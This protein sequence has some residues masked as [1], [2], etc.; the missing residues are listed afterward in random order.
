MLSTNRKGAIAETAIVHQAVRLGIDV[1]KPV[2]EGGRYDLIF[3]SSNVLVRAQCKWAVRQ[4]DVIPVRCYS[5]RRS[6]A[7]FL[8][9]P[10]IADE[11][12]AIVAY[13]PELDRCYFLPL[14]LFG[15]RT[16]IQLRLAEAR[17]NQ[18]AGINWADD[19]TLERL[20]LILERLRGAIAQL[21][22][23]LPG[24]QEGTGSSPVGSTQRRSSKTRIEPP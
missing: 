19:F 24:R 7:G 1:Y 2:V 4:G 14:E 16:A 21:G 11:V 5:S 12:D 13:C 18:R 23:R 8:K 6:P 15:R 20:D 9:R 10:Y 17:N 22:E 3:L